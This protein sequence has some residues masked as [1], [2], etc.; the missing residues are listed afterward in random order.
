MQTDDGSLS[1]RSSINV[2][3]LADVMV[4]LLI[5]FMVVTPMMGSSV[6]DDG[7]Q[8]RCRASRSRALDR[9]SR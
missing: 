4:V 3:P 7:L 8:R 5:I 2:T 6:A 1:L 9:A